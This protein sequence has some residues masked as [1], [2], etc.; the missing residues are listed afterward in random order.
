[1]NTLTILNITNN[2]VKFDLVYVFTI[3]GMSI[4]AYMM[5][6]MFHKKYHSYN[7]KSKPD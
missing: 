2:K 3:I 4:F 7:S 6:Y 5:I 1:M